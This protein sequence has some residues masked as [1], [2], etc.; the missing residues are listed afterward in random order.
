MGAG[1]IG[2]CAR[3]GTSWQEPRPGLLR[4]PSRGVLPVHDRRW[5]A[6][7]AYIP[8]AAGLLYLAVVL[9]VFSRPVVG[10]AMADHLRTELVLDALDIAVGQH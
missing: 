9:D 10:W 2:V 6:D 4:G 7:I 5:V 3:R 8:T 1:R